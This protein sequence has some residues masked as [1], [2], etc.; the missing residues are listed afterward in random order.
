[1]SS[2]LESNGK[3]SDF[4][5]AELLTEA[6]VFQLSGSFRLS[7]ETHKIAVYLEKG[8]VIYAASNLPAHRMREIAVNSGILSA[9]DLYGFSSINNDLQ[10][11]EKL[12]AAGKIMASGLRE[13]QSQQMT[14]VLR[15][16]LSWYAG[17]WVFTP[18]V[19][20]REGLQAET[21]LLP[22]L[23]EAAR[24]APSE[25]VFQRFRR[26]TESFAA[27]SVFPA[28][29]DLHPQEAFLLSRF[30]RVLTI[31]ELRSF[32]GLPDTIL[33]RAVFVLWLGGFLRRYN[34]NGA[35]SEEKL[36]QIQ[37]A[38]IS[39][40]AR[41]A[42]TEAVVANADE[43]PIEP[44]EETK[45]VETVTVPAESDEQKENRELKAFL[46]RV[47]KAQN[48]Y[49]VLGAEPKAE[50][51]EIKK[52]YF[53]LAKSFHPD[54][55]HNAES[56]LRIRLQESFSRV[57]QAYDTLRDKK[58]RELY[59]F[60]IRKQNA[61]AASEATPQTCFEVGKKAF[62]D[63]NFLEAIRQ[64]T[65]AIQLD[66]KVA[67]YHAAYARSLMAV[68]KYQRQAENEFIAALKIEPNNAE[69]RLQLAEFYLEQKLNKRAEGEVRRALVI[70]PNNQYAKRILDNLTAQQSKV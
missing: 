37:N 70:E 41:A 63:K 47:E 11:G 38:K 27:Q 42:V 21:N 15:L 58:S 44:I 51:G 50:D 43:N 34:Y 6:A 61:A 18:L 8:E 32:S 17:D 39:P 52:V 33:L 19:R 29:V 68:P 49:Q 5:L 54:K 56:A 2:N 24:L 62:E 66:P 4:S 28:D 59:D 23:I 57:S 3:L 22:L 67:S 36:A 25:L 55:F 40:A 7:H 14:E 12:V 46:N 31:E 20:I 65:R 16:A 30:D 10:F 53:S 13:L 9:E 48:H 64:F 69:Y 45:K 60:K 1:M 35:F 26:A